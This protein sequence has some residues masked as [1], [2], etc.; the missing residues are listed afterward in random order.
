MT[1]PQTERELCQRIADGSLPSPQIFCRNAFVLLVL[2]EAGA[3]ARADGVAYRADD[4]ITPEVA[5]RAIGL[6][7]LVGRGMGG[8]NYAERCIGT[9]LLPFVDGSRL[10]AVARIFP[11]AATKMTAGA[12]ASLVALTDDDVV[13]LDSVG[14]RLIIEHPR[15]LDHVRVAF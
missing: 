3:R 11:R 15:L 12:R 14:D 1:E 8:R 10:M 13:H 5:Q 6:P 4:W 2:A 7:V 9:I